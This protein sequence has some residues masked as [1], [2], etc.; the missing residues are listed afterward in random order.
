MSEPHAYVF[1]P[2]E[3][4]TL[5]GS[6]ANPDHPVGRRMGY[7]AVGLL[8]ALTSGLGN[9]LITVNLGFVQG[10]LNLYSDEAQWLTAAYFMT[11]VTGNLVLVKY[12]QE[13]GLQP[14]VC[15]TL[16]GYAVA[17]L[18]HLLVHGFWTAVAVRAASGLAAAGITTIILY[19]FMQAMTAPKRLVGVLIGISI[20]QL[21]TPLARIISPHLLEWDDWHMTYWLELGLA[22]ATLAAVN[23]LP[24]PP[25]ECSKA[26]EKEDALTIGLLMPGLWLLV[27]VMSEGRI[28]WWTDTPWLGWALAGSI[29]LIAI[30]LSV[31]H[32]RTNPLLNTRWLGT[33]Q[34]VRLIFAASIARILLSEQAFGSV[35][36]LGIFGLINDQ[37]VTLNVIICLAS[38]AGLITSIV[39]LDPSNTVRPFAISALLIAIGAWIDMHATSQ[40]RPVNFYVSQAFI[41]FA[42]LYFIGPAIVTGLARVLLAG[43][44]NFISFAVL[45][46]MSQNLG[47][48]IGGTLLGTLQTWREKFHSN[49]LVSEIIPS[50]PQVAARIRASA[51]PVAHVIGDPVLQGAQG[52]ALFA[53]QVAREANV[54]AYNDV[55]ELVFIAACATCIWG[56]YIRVGMLRRGERS[57]LEVL[58][59]VLKAQAEKMK[60]DAAG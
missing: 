39:T 1:K 49:Q 36:F 14:F 60:K 23:L 56:I 52:T 40:T 42:A 33:R 41:G 5:P 38:I 43:P 58:G 12:R 13:Y 21:A 55:F 10:A 44:K 45:F 15:Y 22:L 16:A 25:S 8:I 11:N 27:A 24:L 50:D 3:R 54:L 32:M 6:P 31:E 53:Q 34:M 29:G 30:A 46:N 9:A 59:E 47:G 20:P 48:L 57:P 28:Y 37:F 18:A 2:H 17:T 35:G 19:Y 7:M 4:P 51:A 26:F